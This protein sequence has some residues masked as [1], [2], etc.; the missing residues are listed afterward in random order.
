MPEDSSHHQTLAE[1]E[2]MLEPLLAAMI[3]DEGRWI[4]V[5]ERGTAPVR[6]V[7][8]LA[9]EGSGSAVVAEAISDAYLDDGSQLSR[10]EIGSLRQLGWSLADPEDDN[11][12]IIEEAPGRT[13]HDLACRMLATLRWAFGCA[14]E[15]PCLITWWESDVRSP[16]E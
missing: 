16:E 11:W 15:E 7:Q 5:I 10:Y 2:T 8:C 9:L 14:P 12:R 3:G 13:V 1:L 6:Y 4:T